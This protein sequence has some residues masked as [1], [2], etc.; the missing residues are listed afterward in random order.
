MYKNPYE[1]LV[2]PID[3]KLKAAEFGEQHFKANQVN[4]NYVVGPNN[5]PA[6]V[7]IPAQMGTWESYRKV[8]IPLSK[9]FQV[10]AVDIRGH[11]K[12]SWTPG[13]IIALWCAANV[14]E[15]TAGIILED[16][17]MFSAEM[18]RFKQLAP[19][20]QYLKISA[21]HVIHMYKP[22]AFVK[23]VLTF[24]NKLAV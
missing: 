19:S 2:E 18:P 22:K 1:H 5:G 11:G 23:A 13:G 7:L 14:P 9:D 15:R 12:S 21:N 20:S 4:I 3:P 16:A 8:L 6:L 24:S 10:Y 17:P